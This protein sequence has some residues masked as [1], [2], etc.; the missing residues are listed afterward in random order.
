MSAESILCV[1]LGNRTWNDA[2]LK[3]SQQNSTGNESLHVLD[4]SHA[5]RRDAPKNRDRAK[6]E[7]WGYLLDD[8]I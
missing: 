6:P 5:N 8:N 2:G 1:K 4:K 3:E 7:G